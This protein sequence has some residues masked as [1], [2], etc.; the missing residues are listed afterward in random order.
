M[1]YKILPCHPVS[2]KKRR[3]PCVETTPVHPYIYMTWYQRLNRLSDL[4]EIWFRNSLQEA[5][6]QVYAFRESSNSDSH[7]IR[8]KNFHE[9]PPVISIFL[10]P[11]GWHYIPSIST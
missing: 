6:Q 3:K 5:F 9:L 4:H 10:D 1:S 8:N 11:C 7:I 2:T